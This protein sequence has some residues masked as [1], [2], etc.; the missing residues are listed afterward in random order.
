[1]NIKPII[2]RNQIEDHL[3][4]WESNVLRRPS[5]VATERGCAY[6]R[7]AERQRQSGLRARARR[8]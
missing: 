5:G 6:S 1:M 7:Q 4:F 3:E 8:I 2:R